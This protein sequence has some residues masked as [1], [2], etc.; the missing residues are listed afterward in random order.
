METI[1]RT[2]AIQH[3]KHLP[4]HHKLMNEI[5]EFFRDYA[6]IEGAFVS[7]STATGGMDEY[8]DLDLGFL[9]T[10]N[11]TREK[12]WNSRW[13][14][15]IAPWFH[16]F[17]ADHIKPNF[18]IYFFDPSVHV[19]FN[20][21][22]KD[23]LPT[24]SGAPFVVAWDKSDILDNWAIQA[25]QKTVIPIDWSGVVHDDERFWAW[26]HYCVSHALRGEVYDAAFCMKDLRQIVENWE[27]MINGFVKF[28]SRKVESRWNK[29]FFDEISLTFCKPD[30]LSVRKAFQ[31]LIDIQLIQRE[32]IQTETGILWNTNKNAIQKIS[33]MVAS[34]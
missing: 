3:T 24:P 26:I 21:Y 23:D 2:E 6:G 16:R 31:A 4:H 14:W 22:V 29:L 1:I 5:C 25:N 33:S 10:D 30:R 34:L 11:A 18:V 19:D 17:D 8:S 7:G 15:D 32:K 9:V 20:F 13:D 28:N 12:I 27:A